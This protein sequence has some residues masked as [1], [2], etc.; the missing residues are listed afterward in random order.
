MKL[1]GMDQLS[2]ILPTVVSVLFFQLEYSKTLLT[3]YLSLWACLQ[4]LIVGI[5][6]HRN[7]ALFAIDYS[8]S[9]V[10]L[11]VSS[12]MLTF[13]LAVAVL[14]RDGHLRTLLL[15]SHSLVSLVNT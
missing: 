1:N 13:Y 7:H 5:S 2:E 15:M 11:D 14:A 4:M 9:T 3:L 6:L 12:H 10:S 8:F